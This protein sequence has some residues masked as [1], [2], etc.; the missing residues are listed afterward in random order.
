M[1]LFKYRPHIDGL[2]AIAVISILIFH[3]HKSLLPGGFIGVDVFF[4]ISG[5]L[6]TS[7]II[8]E[9][10]DKQFSFWRFYQ[11][12][13]SRIFPVF[14]LVSLVTL[15][16]ASVLYTSQDFASVGAVIV[17][18]ALS[19]A[20][21]KL[22][23]QG[24][25]FELSPDAQPLL[26]MWSLS[27]E[28]QFYLIFP[29]IVYCTYRIDTT[30]RRLSLILI[31]IAILS[32]AA[33]VVLTTKNPTWAFY[34]LPTRAW[35]LLAGCILA[36]YQYQPSNHYSESHLANQR[37]NG[38]LSNIGILTIIV[39]FFTIHEGIPFPGFVAVIPVL[40]TLLLIGCPQNQ[41]SISE[42]WLSHPYLVFIGK[43]SYSLY[44]WHWPIYSFVDYA[45]YGQLFIIRAVLKIFLTI[46]FSFV[47]YYWFEKPIRSYLNQPKRKLFG[48]T[49]FAIAVITFVVIGLF[50]NTSNYINANPNSVK[51][52]G[53]TFNSTLS[54][55]V[56]VLMGDSNGA[57]YGLSLKQI[58]KEMQIKV[59]LIS[60]AA[61]DPLPDGQL[62]KDS[63]IFLS[64]AN[65]EITIFVAAWSE[66][67]GVNRDRFKT[68]LSQILQKSKYVILITQPPIL[69]KYA[70]RQAIREF[71]Q[72]PIFEDIEFS[73][74]RK[75]TNTFLR[76]H[77]NDR[78]HVLDIEYLFK[79]SN[80]EIRFTDSQGRQ[81]YQ[82]AGHISSYGSEMVKQLMLK[83]ISQILAMPM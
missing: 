33:Y 38:I 75:D 16:T 76:S 58:A 54:K 17:A 72:R 46:T 25:Y 63:L 71:G 65:P 7:I 52:G 67:I 34:L 43:M 53:I 1:S 30:R 31:A 26:H 42:R 44:L 13:I 35:E 21:L 27:V 68:A 48:F 3:F 11:R 60:V 23:L 57:M 78:V 14:F 66:K 47:S 22:M 49:I 37:L 74:L 50:V 10:E 29:L 4:V 39:A 62:Y 45:L 20:N 36:T 2:R 77:Q 70:S 12:R 55:P 56:V 80:G 40:A 51:D 9:C 5:Y 41:Q 81:L 82:D 64:H 8:S 59:H 79:K 6:I 19:V 32:L 18:A 69:P 73:S 83:E 24:N 28:E 15:A 61:G